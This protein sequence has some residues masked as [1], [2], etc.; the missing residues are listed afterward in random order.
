MNSDLFDKKHK[1]RR[2]QQSCASWKANPKS[3][4][5]SSALLAKSSMLPKLRSIY[6]NEA[7][8]AANAVI[9]ALKVCSEF[10]SHFSD[11]LHILL[12]KIR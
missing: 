11:K 1:P 8:S 3:D 5:I 10:G 4:A 6:T 2:Q 9:V 7:R 12:F